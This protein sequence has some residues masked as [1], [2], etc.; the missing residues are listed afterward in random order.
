[1]L[2][3]FPK[4]KFASESQRNVQSSS[5]KPKK[6]NFCPEKDTEGCSSKN[7][8]LT[9]ASSEIRKWIFRCYTQLTWAHLSLQKEKL[10]LG[11]G[12]MT[13]G[14]LLGCNAEEYRS[15]AGHMIRA[16]CGEIYSTVCMLRYDH[17]W[18]DGHFE[19]CNRLYQTTSSTTYRVPRQY[20]HYCFLVFRRDR[21]G[22]S[23]WHIFHFSLEDASEDE[24]L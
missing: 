5:Y 3:A 9:L 22:G 11:W 21:T 15:V 20:F 8:E 16:H 1:M 6:V 2:W 4:N 24:S 13:S 14:T 17:L 18:C 7:S 10:F 19:H 23:V 12:S